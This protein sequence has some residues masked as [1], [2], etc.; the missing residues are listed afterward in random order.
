MKTA[1]AFDPRWLSLLEQV[2]A[3]RLF[4]QVPDV[5]VDGIALVPSRTVEYADHAVRV[6]EY[7]AVSCSC[8]DNRTRHSCAH[9]MAMAVTLWQREMVGLGAR[10][11]LC[12]PHALTAEYWPAFCRMLVERYLSPSPERVR[13][14]K[15]RRFEAVRRRLEATGPPERPRLFADSRATAGRQRAARPVALL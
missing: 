2:L 1:P 15:R 3:Q 11:H 6:D 10:S 12:D 4:E 13:A 7:A 9:R 8:L 14:Q 5:A